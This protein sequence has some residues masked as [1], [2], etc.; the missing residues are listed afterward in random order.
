MEAKRQVIGAGRFKQGCLAL[1][2]Q[3]AERQIEIVITKR[4]RPVARL[5][6]V[7]GREQREQAIL[8]ELRG[9]GR[10][11]VGEEEFLRPSMELAGWQ[12]V[13]GDD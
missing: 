8:A 6:P 11:L 12:A 10:M 1:L 7:E 9:R 5:V 13:R 2:D 3:V 4:G